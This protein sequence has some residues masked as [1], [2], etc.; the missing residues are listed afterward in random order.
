MLILLD[1]GN[2]SVTYGLHSNGKLKAF[3]SILFNDIPLLIK[4]FVNSGNNNNI[5]VII[6]SVV[7]KNT[8]FILVMLKRYKGVR[9]WI[10]GANLRVP[11]RHRYRGRKKPGIDR[12]V[13]IFGALTAYKPPFLVIDFGTAITFDYVSKRG[14][15]EGGMIIPGPETAF[16]ALIE[17]AALLPKKI[18]LPFRANSF[19]GRSTGECL[20]AG[21]LEGYGALTDGLIERFKRK[22]GP[23]KVIATGGFASH[24]KPYSCRLQVIDPKLSIKALLSLYQKYS[25]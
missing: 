16:Q 13:N 14:I 21:T 9:V 6:S 4:N 23:L 20:T 12:L 2:T 17:K 19:L 5:N 25:A 15:F 24:L 3:C 10:A 7:P 18:R 8:R 11:V 1:I 22:F